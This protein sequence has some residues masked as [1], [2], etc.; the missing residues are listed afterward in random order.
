MVNL[1]I[2]AA[3]I[4][5]FTV[6]WISCPRC[7]D[8]SKAVECPGT[9]EWPG[10]ME[11][12]GRLRATGT[13]SAIMKW[14]KPHFSYLMSFLDQMTNAEILVINSW[15]SYL[16]NMD[17]MTK[18]RNTNYKQLYPIYLFLLQILWFKK[19]LCSLR[20]SARVLFGFLFGF[21]VAH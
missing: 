12:H 1:K 15:T 17:K 5:E 13:S 3:P 6:N 14:I 21:S 2:C 10:T 16:S 18:R 9:L 20:L 7:S 4:T 8:L 11:W 19:I